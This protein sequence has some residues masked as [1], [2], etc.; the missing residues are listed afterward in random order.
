MLAGD[1]FT[2]LS[3]TAWRTLA[4]WIDAFLAGAIVV[5]GRWIINGI[6]QLSGANAPLS[7]QINNI[8]D[9]VALAAVFYSYRVFTEAKYRTSLGKWSVK[10]DIITTQPRWRGA[11]IRNLWIVLTLFALTPLPWVEVTI[12]GILGLSVVVFGRSPFDALAGALVVRR[13]AE[14]KLPP[15]GH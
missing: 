5:A 7:G 8:Y 1:V 2:R 12:L 13:V 15:A 6:A 10:M 11:V 14:Q 4:W 3:L 9:V